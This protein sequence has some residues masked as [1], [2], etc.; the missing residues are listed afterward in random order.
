MTSSISELREAFAPRTET[1][2]IMPDPALIARHAELDRQLNEVLLQRNELLVSNVAS[3]DALRDE[4]LDLQRQ[5]AESGHDFTF[6]AIG[7]GAWLAA[8]AKHPPT[9]KQAGE[10]YSYNPDTFPPVALRA[11][12]IEPELT[13]DDAQWLATQLDVTEF[14]R[15]FDACV[16]VNQGTAAGPKSVPASVLQLLSAALATTPAVTA[17]PEASS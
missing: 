12:C 11:S 6:Q 7:R 4:V 3:V 17:S 14:D 10:G 13:A 16:R 5:I 15:L 1:V 8:I 9:K 2:R